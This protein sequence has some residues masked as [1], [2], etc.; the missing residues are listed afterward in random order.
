M[1]VLESIF[2]HARSAPDKAALIAN[3]QPLSYGAFAASIVLARRHLQ[4]QAIDRERVAVLFTA[5]LAQAWIVGLALRS[6]GVTNV[7]GRSSAD[8]EGLGLDAVSVVSTA[9]AAWPELTT[10]AA[11]AGAPRIVLPPDDYAA[12]P[13]I[14]EEPALAADK[15]GGQILLT[16]GTTGLYKKVLI[17]PAHEAA[18][19]MLRADLYGLG[20]GSVVNMFDFGGWTVA[21]YQTPIS[22]WSQGGAVVLYQGPECWRAL[23]TPGITLTYAQPLMVAELLAAPEDAP[24]RNDAMTLIVGAGVLPLAHWRAARERLT[25]DI[26]TGYGSTEAGP[27]ALTRIETPEDLAWHRIHPAFLVQ[28]VDDAHRPLPAGRSGAVRVRT[29]GIDGYLGDEAATR[30]FFRDGFFYPGDLGVLR[31]D[32]RLSVLGRITD[33]INVRGDKLP[34]TPIETQLQEALGAKAV[35][36]FSAPDKDGAESVHVAI[37]RGRKIT[38]DQLRA[39]LLAALPQLP[40]AYV[41]AVDGFARNPMG[42]I[43]R[44]ALRARLLA[45]RD[46]PGGDSGV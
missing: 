25:R 19:V 23:A 28:V 17:D 41:H 20:P 33:V 30:A 26:H 37:E 32:G 10:T 31:E 13:A 16:S 44:A 9:S 3:G 2:A 14:G 1:A 42:K 39:A 45:G 18:S 24:L 4:A 34:T 6:L 36:V 5:N 38:A 27:C 11:D 15:A 35:C 7:S 12:A 40:S 21:G 43:D 29:S 8:I 46:G 22:V